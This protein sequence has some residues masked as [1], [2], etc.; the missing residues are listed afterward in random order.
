MIPKT[1]ILGIDYGSA[2]IGLAFGR[3]GIVTPIKVISGKN[4]YTAISDILRV[5]KE[6]AVG[7]IVLGL[8]LTIDDKE[9]LKSKEVRNFAKLLKIKAKIP[10]E[11]I[12]EFYTS[13]DASI[14]MLN[15]GVSQKNRRIEDHYSAAL[16]L[17][18]YFRDFV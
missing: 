16:I 4:A 3:E 10:I 12:N 14:V 11:F 15:S 17:K 9:T 5:I 2:N 1:G 7:K 8:P 13:K 6:Y 18:R